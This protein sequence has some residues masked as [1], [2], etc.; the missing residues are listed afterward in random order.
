[1]AARTARTRRDR[2]RVALPIVVAVAAAIVAIVMAVGAGGA[3]DE[4]ADGAAA[5]APRAGDEPA[6]GPEHR[7]TGPM[8][9]GDDDAPVV[10]VMY[11]EFQCPFCGKFARDTEPELVERFVDDGTLRI[12]WRD[13]PYLGPESLQAAVAGRAAAEQG[14]FW[15]LADALFADQAPP[16]SG[17]LTAEHLVDVASGL[18]LDAER[19]RADLADADLVEAVRAD[20]D[21]AVGFGVTG[22]PA[23][24]VNGQVIMGAQPVEVFVEAIEQAANAAR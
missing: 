9:K 11:S 6:A 7:G 3:P 13:L 1:M 20:V 19:F 16:N 18:G 14:G 5:D 23:F 17:R 4:A 21:E 12:E 8:A 22:T 10:M 15:E 24:F 2:T